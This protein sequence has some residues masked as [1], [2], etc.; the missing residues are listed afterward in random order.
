LLCESPALLIL[1]ARAEFP[2]FL[3]ERVE[4]PTKASY[5]FKPPTKFVP[6]Q[7][8]S[9]AGKQSLPNAKAAAKSAC[10]FCC[11]GAAVLREQYG[12]GVLPGGAAAAASGSVSSVVLW[13]VKAAVS[14]GMQCAKL[15][16]LKACAD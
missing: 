2:E 9:R 1:Q 5:C 4:S 8:R 12:S 10:G 11:T 15:N 16:G 3:W 7:P 13:F 14:A 6:T